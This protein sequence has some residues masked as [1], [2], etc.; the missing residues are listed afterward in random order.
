MVVKNA[1]ETLDLSLQIDSSEATKVLWT[2]VKA[3]DARK[4]VNEGEFRCNR[5]LD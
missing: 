5:S 1:G 3:L 2:K 4:G